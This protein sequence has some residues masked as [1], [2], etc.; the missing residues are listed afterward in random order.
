MPIPNPRIADHLPADTVA[1]LCDRFHVRRLELFGSAATNIGFN[2]TTSDIDVLVEFATLSPAEYANA[3]FG[4]REALISL[5]GRSVDLVT[6]AGLENPF[7]RCRVDAERIP[8]FQ[9]V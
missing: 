6:D 7:L 8:L 1:H 4:L 9:A 3:Y 2:A 5:S